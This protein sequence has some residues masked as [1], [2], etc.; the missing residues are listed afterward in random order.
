[1]TNPLPTYKDNLFQSIREFRAL[2]GTKAFW[3]LPK[4][5]RDGALKALALAY[6]GMGA[7]PID[8]V[9]TGNNDAL[10]DMYGSM[11]MGTVNEYHMRGEALGV[12]TYG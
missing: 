11:F 5:N 3:A 2:M 4:V 10:V 9:N 6:A 12:D 7:D 8:F 1:M